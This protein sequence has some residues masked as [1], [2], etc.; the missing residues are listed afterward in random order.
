MKA[1][2]DREADALYVYVAPDRGPIARTVRMTDDV[3][4]DID[5]DGQ[6]V[7]VEVLHA[8]AM[9]D[10]AGTLAQFKITF[11]DIEMT[12]IGEAAGLPTM[13]LKS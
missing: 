9:P 7:G 10:L 13:P 6:I 12:F 11:R 8:A 3:M 5:A 2:Y 1:T 4:V